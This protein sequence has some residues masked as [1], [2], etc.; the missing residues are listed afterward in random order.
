MT[1]DDR[2][3]LNLVET[4]ESPPGDGEANT[5]MEHLPPVIWNPAATNAHP[6][7]VGRRITADLLGRMSRLG[8][9]WFGIAVTPLQ[10]VR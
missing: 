7:E 6:D 2:N 4:L 8:T 5:L 1:V 3:R 9:A 10:L